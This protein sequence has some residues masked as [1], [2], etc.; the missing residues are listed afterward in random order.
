MMASLGSQIGQFIERKHAEDALRV[1]QSELTH[2]SRVMTMGELTASIAHEVNQPLLGIV[3]SASSCSRWLAAEPPNLQRAQRALERIMEAGTRATAVIDRVRTL[4][5]REPLRAEAVDVNEIVRDVMAM[6]RHELQ[7]SGVS[8]KTRLADQL[9]TVPGDR[10]QLQQVVLN[11]MLN[12]IEATREIEGRSR[13]V[14]VASRFEAGKGV[15]V[16][17]R[18]SGVGLTPDSR[19]RVF[20]AF[21]TTKHSGLGMGLSICK[22]IVEAHGG[23]I[24]AMPKAPHGAIFRFWLP[25]VDDT[26]VA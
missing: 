14:S 8:L 16:E 6:V 11:L 15:Q 2:L 24:T 21:F 19:A 12:A 4:V 20:E 18:D 25:L 10:V 22:S 1:A 5:K 23:R 7:R 13:Q 17:V 26:G 9:P 3:S